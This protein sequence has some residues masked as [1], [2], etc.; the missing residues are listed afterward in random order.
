MQLLVALFLLLVGADFRNLGNNLG[1]VKELA[2]ELGGEEMKSAIEGAEKICKEAEE[3][4]G[5]ISAFRAAANAD[6]GKSGSNEQAKGGAPEEGC[7]KS[8]DGSE[9]NV[10]CNCEFSQHGFPLA[11]IRGIADEGILFCLSRYIAVGE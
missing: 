11:P 6:A 4:E 1:S 3:I 10:S 5:L 2:E 9:G 7:G 8:F